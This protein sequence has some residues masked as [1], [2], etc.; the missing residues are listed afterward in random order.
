MELLNLRRWYQSTDFAWIWKKIFCV[1]SQVVNI[2]H[3]LE[4]QI[5]IPLVQKCTT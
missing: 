5:W 1:S 4:D 2:L 3:H